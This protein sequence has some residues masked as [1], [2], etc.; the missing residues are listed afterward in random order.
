VVSGSSPCFTVLV[1]IADLKDAVGL[2][3]VAA[4]LV[5]TIVGAGQARIVAL[6]LVEIPEDMALSEGAVA[7]RLH[8]QSLGRL[9]RVGLA[10]SVELRTSV[11]VAR[12][13]WQGIVEAAT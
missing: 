9:R 12:Q 3:R 6:S 2:V 11:R 10:G 7:A 1:P 4:A 5:Q 13:S 8:R